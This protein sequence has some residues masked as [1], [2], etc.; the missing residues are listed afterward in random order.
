MA[1]GAEA[2]F[3]VRATGYCLQLQW[4]KDLCDLSDGGR[5]RGTCTDTLRILEVEARDKGHYRCLVKNDVGKMFSNEA[6]LPSTRMTATCACN[7]MWTP[8]PG[9]LA[10]ICEYRQ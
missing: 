10:C 9:S 3:Q 5:Y 7:G 6:F 8:D 1:L 4:Q 2:V